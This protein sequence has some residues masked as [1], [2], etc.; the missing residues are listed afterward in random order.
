MKNCNDEA[1][2]RFSGFAPGLVAGFVGICIR[3]ISPQ[4]SK[5]VRRLSVVVLKSILP[6]QTEFRLVPVP[7]DT[8]PSASFR[9]FVAEPLDSSLSSFACSFAFFFWRR[10]SAWES[11]GTSGSASASASASLSLESLPSSSTGAAVFLFLFRLEGSG[12]GL[13]A[14]EDDEDAEELMAV[15]E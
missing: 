15:R 9:F 5:K 8:V 6:T 3:V 14:L 11:A 10:R 13:E 12:I 2:P 7:V 4:P 1:D